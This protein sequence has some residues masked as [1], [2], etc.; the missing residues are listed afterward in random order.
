MFDFIKKKKNPI[1]ITIS[2]VVFVV[3]FFTSPFLFSKQGVIGT[4]AGDRE[5]THIS[6][7][8]NLFNKGVYTIENGDTKESYFCT[9]Q[10]RMGTPSENIDQKYIRDDGMFST[11]NIR[12]TSGNN[13]L[14]KQFYY[15]D[16]KM[17]A[18]WDESL[19]LTKIS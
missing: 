19:I 12:Y 16:K 1:L 13:P 5:D 6:I 3:L 4:F 2:L 7:S 17:F 10:N 18:Y 14:Q 9:W 15:V 11:I 8:L